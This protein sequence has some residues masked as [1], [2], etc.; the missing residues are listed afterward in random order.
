MKVFERPDYEEKYAKFKVLYQQGKSMDYISLAID[1]H[2]RWLGGP[3]FKKRLAREIGKDKMFENV[4]RVEHHNR[5]K[6]TINRIMELVHGLEAD[7]GDD[8]D[9]FDGDPR[10]EECHKLTELRHK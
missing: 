2:K 7:Y 9:A 1:V 5:N 10:L 6:D 8:Y 3:Y 4:D